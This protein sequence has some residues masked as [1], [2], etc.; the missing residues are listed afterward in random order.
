MIGQGTSLSSCHCFIGLPTT[1]KSLVNETY[2]YN[3]IT[4]IG[5]MILKGTKASSHHYIHGDVEDSTS[6]KQTL[7][8]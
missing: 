1:L 6:W 5:E 4:C 8:A 2:R 7:S 3:K